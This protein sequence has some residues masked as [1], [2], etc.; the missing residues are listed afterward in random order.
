MF[1]RAYKTAS[2]LPIL[3]LIMKLCRQ[4]NVS[5]IRGVENKIWATKMQ[6]IERMKD[7]TKFEMPIHKPLAFQ[8]Q[9]NPVP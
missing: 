9:T 3:C 8:I 7:D 1:V 5:I 2:T 6:D 4:E